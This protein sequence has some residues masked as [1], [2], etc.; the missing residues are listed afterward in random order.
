[1][2]KCICGKE[3]EKWNVLCS[4]FSR[5]C[6]KQ[7]DSTIDGWY[8]LYKSLYGKQVDFIIEEYKNE[9]LCCADLDSWAVKMI[10][11]MGLKRT[12]SQEKQ[13]DRYK[14]KVKSTLLSRYEVVNPSQCDF[15]KQKKIDTFTKKHGSY[16]SWKTSQ[17]RLMRSGLQDIKEN[18]Q[19]RWNEIRERMKKGVR[20]KWGVD[21]V[22]QVPEIAQ[23]IAESVK[24]RLS[25]LPVEERQKMTEN[26]RSAIKRDL[27][28]SIEVRVQNVLNHLGISFEKHLNIGNRNYD[29]VIQPNIVIECQ[30]DYW[31]AN[32]KIYNE[33]D[34]LYNSQ[35]AKDIWDR[36]EYKRTLAIKHGFTVIP[37]WESDINSKSEENLINFVKEEI[38]NV[39][40]TSK[41]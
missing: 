24:R 13:T 41:R 25:I 11:L 31:H 28:S 37:L 17:T 36:D 4:H 40:S 22:T 32:P 7:F 8:T 14:N 26:A 23:K 18:D 38:E 39:C 27:E 30:G 29:I 33:T 16:E 34:V 15:V 3:V 35:T 2:F 6:I 10:T 12:H 19:E 1:M 20:D 9:N 21:N 5:V